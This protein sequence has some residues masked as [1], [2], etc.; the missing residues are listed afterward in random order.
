MIS[1]PPTLNTYSPAST[2][3]SRPS[4]RDRNRSAVAMR[5]TATASVSSI[6]CRVAV[7]VI[8]FASEESTIRSLKGFSNP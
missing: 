7:A 2:A 4:E 6:A 3:K 5:F 1:F 8:A